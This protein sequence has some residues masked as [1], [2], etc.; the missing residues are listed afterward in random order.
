MYA[1]DGELIE[2]IDEVDN[3]IKVIV[4]S[5]DKDNFQGLTNIKDGYT[6]KDL[7]INNAKEL[8]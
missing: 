3:D 7:R 2:S 1:I 5:D 4:V 6:I 8:K